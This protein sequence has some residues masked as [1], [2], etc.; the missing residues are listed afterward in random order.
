METVVNQTPPE[1][2]R[3]AKPQH[4]TQWP[5]LEDVTRPYI[6]TAQAGFYLHRRDQTLRQWACKENG[7]IQPR[8]IHGRLAWP[9]KDIRDL[10]GV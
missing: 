8:R 3:A 7:P 10:L 6:P 5:R 2:R 4:A 9:V 1:T